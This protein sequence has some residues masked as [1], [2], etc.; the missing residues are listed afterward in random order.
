M[1]DKQTYEKKEC[2]YCGKLVSTYPMTWKGH[3]K[4]HGEEVEKSQTAEAKTTKPATKARNEDLQVL[5]ERA[6]AV[7]EKFIEA[8]EAF[9]DS[10]LSSHREALIEIYIGKEAAFGIPNPNPPLDGSR[11]WIKKPTVHPYFGRKEDR[12]RDVNRGYM[13]VLDEH[14]EH[15]ND[16][17][18]W[19]YAIPYAQ[20]EKTQSAYGK[21]SRQLMNQ[22]TEK[23]KEMKNDKDIRDNVSEEITTEKGN[24]YNG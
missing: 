9:V 24:I 6:E 5:I 2:P 13:P 22:S 20:F 17:G 15:V 11:P 4:Q 18:D 7:Q 10:Q 14:G 21:H 1:S 12:Q 3:M 16:Q 19:L 23:M 8:P